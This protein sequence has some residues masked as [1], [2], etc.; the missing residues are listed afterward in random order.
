MIVTPSPGDDVE[1]VVAAVDDSSDDDAEGKE[2]APAREDGA[3]AD[4]ESKGEPASGGSFFTISASGG[5]GSED[6][7]ARSE[8]K[9]GVADS[10]SA[11]P[12]KALSQT[13]PDPPSVGVWSLQ[14]KRQQHENEDRARCVLGMPSPA[15]PVDFFS[16]LDGHGGGDCSTF[17]Q[18]KLHTFVAETEAWSRGDFSTALSD[19]IAACEKAFLETGMDSGTCAVVGLLVGGGIGEGVSPGTERKLYIAN[20]GDCRAVLCSIDGKSVRQVTK[21]HKPSDPEEKERVEAAGGLIFGGRLFGI[22]AV[23]RSIGDAQLKGDGPG[24]TA[25]S[26]VPD[27]YEETLTHDGSNTDAVLVMACDGV[28]DELTNEDVAERAAIGLQKGAKRAARKLSS[29]HEVRD[30]ESARV[31]DPGAHL[32]ARRITSDAASTGYDDCT[33]VVVP[34]VRPPVEPP[35]VD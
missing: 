1:E 5:A 14:C 16:V 29:V 21:D 28:W 10:G 6:A 22:I 12:S 30:G 25:L 24:G 7:G 15:G 13:E 33:A 27:V 19:G 32:A 11:S 4:G 2:G 3:G 9:D 23:V 8:G 26:A 35:S 31:R 17:C 18:D 34:F 20:C